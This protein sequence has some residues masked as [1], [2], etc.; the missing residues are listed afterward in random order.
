MTLRKER[1]K[2]ERV[3]K[4]VASAI[5]MIFSLVAWRRLAAM[6]TRSSMR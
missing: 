5:S 4:P 1:L 3:V 2:L 6:R